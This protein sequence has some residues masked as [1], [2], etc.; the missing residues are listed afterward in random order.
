[1]ILVW[2]QLK[3]RTS[4]PFSTKWKCAR[5]ATVTLRRWMFGRKGVSHGG[6]VHWTECL[7]R[8]FG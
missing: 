7:R 8:D 1:M 3:N 4:G 5:D 6:A 2:V